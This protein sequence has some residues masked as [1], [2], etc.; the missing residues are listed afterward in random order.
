VTAPLDFTKIGE[1]LRIATG[2]V[3]SSLVRVSGVLV[4]DWPGDLTAP[5][6]AAADAVVTPLLRT[7]LAVCAAELLT[8]VDAE[9][10]RR[11][12]ALG[13][14]H[15]G[16]T[17]SSSLPAQSKWIGLYTIRLSP[18]LVYPVVVR[19]MD[20]TVE[21]VIADAVLLEA[22][23]MTLAG[24]VRARLDAGR[25][26]KGSVLAA[27]TTTAAHAAYTSYLLSPP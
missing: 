26:V 23:Y 10:R 21:R 1:D 4:V 5:Q 18:L 12:E 2:A 24:T 15:G 20:D 7:D 16:Q 9:T 8:L 22:M 19:T 17:F 11:V 13:F 25:V 27:T 14:T 6:L 3:P